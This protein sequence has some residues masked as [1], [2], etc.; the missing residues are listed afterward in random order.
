MAQG[1]PVA[2]SDIPIFRE[3]AAEAAMYFDPEDPQSI[4]EAITALTDETIW[5]R[6]SAA[7]RTQSQVFD[8]SRSAQALIDLIRT[9][10]ERRGSGS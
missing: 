8:W 2:V 5:A 10:D 7:G 1:V 9:V 6:Q 4:A 3:I